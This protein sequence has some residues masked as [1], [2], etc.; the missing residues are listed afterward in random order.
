M[1]MSIKSTTPRKLLN[2]LY[3][4]SNAAVE[5]SRQD[6]RENFLTTVTRNPRIKMRCVVQSM[7]FSLTCHLI[8]DIFNNLRGVVLLIDMFIW[9]ARKFDRRVHL[10]DTFSKASIEFSCISNEFL[11]TFCVDQMNV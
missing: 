4:I 3:Q 10:A 2:R 9:S 5:Y 1:N 6:I 8:F 7:V 11:S